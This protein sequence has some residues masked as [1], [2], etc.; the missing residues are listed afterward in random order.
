MARCI[1]P[2]RSPAEVLEPLQAV[3]PDAAS[4]WRHSSG[5][6]WSSVDAICWNRESVDAV[7][8][9]SAVPESFAFGQRRQ[10]PL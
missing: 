7:S 9:T 6:G 10:R 1:G 8:R 5:G 2:C 3:V 4:P